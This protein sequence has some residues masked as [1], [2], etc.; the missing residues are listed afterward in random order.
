MRQQK[1]QC[2]YNYKEVKKVKRIKKHVKGLQMS[3]MM[4]CLSKNIL[5]LSYWSRNLSRS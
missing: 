1:V 5:F 2:C 3:I 4:F